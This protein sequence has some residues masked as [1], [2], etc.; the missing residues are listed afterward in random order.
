MNGRNVRGKRAFDAYNESVGGKTWDG[1]PI[2]PWELL[3]ERIREA[4]RCASDAVIHGVEC[5]D[6]GPT[7]QDRVD[8]ERYAAEARASER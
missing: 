5:G 8:G 7:E 2:P 4:W 3:T 6:E 1:K